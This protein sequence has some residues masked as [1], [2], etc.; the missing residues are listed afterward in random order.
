MPHTCFCF[1]VILDTPHTYGAVL[2]IL[3]LIFISGFDIKLEAS[4]QLL[5][6]IVSKNGAPK[7]FAKQ[8]GWQETLTHLFILKPKCIQTESFDDTL[9]DVG[10]K[11]DDSVTCEKG[12]NFDETDEEGTPD[13]QIG[14][15]ESSDF[16]RNNGDTLTRDNALSC[17][18]LLGQSGTDAKRRPAPHPTTLDLPSPG[19][20]GNPN[21]YEPSETPTDTPMYEQQQRFDDFYNRPMSGS[22]SSSTST[23]DVNMVGGRLSEECGSVIRHPSSTSVSQLS[24]LSTT[25]SLDYDLPS[26]LSSSMSHD[27]IKDRVLDSLG[28]R[29][30]FMMDIM[31]D[32]EELTQN[33]LIVLFTVMW[34]GV[35]GSDQSAMKVCDVCEMTVSNR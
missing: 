24:H 14:A 17:D 4:R 27:K 22:R 23:E 7:N 30:S 12:H 5:S 1:H 19:R 3:Q 20:K 35:E 8:L 10:A 28:L 31:E 11:G 21:F 6:I 25:E 33:L 26:P 15:I 29:G 2:A 9:E 32:T 18:K 34:K 16:V 13:K